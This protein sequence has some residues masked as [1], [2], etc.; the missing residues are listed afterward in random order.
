MNSRSN[1]PSRFI[2]LYVENDDA[3]VLMCER[4]F[5]PHEELELRSVSDGA[6]VI[7]WLEGQGSYANRAFFPMPALLVLDSRLDDMTALEILRWLRAQRRFRDLPVILHVGSTP[8]HERNAYHDLHVAAVVEKDSTCRALV[9]RVR[10]V[11]HGE[12]AGR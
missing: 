12:F 5:K 4:A 3:D 8:T 1:K 11:L 10:D 7:D 2:V 9:E 6:S